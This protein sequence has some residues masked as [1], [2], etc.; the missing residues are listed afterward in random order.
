[1]A[2]AT[3]N[4]QV[5]L[6]NPGHIGA[7][8]CHLNLHK[9]FAMPHGGAVRG[10]DLRRRAPQ[11]LP[12]AFG[13]SDGR[14]RRHHRR[15]IGLGAALLLPNYGYIKMLG[16]AIRLRYEMAIVNASYMSAALASSSEPTIR[17]RRAA[18][19]MR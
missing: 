6:T 8:V 11:S 10:S 2:Q 17:A 12:P 18:W 13:Y 5:G 19:V 7:D 14:R 4:A 3:V 1:M 16:E 15:G 9:T